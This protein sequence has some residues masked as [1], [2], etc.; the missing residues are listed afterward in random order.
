M[1]RWFGRWVLATVVPALL[2]LLGAGVVGLVTGRAPQTLFRR[3]IHA[4]RVPSDATRAAA[5]GVH[6]LFRSHVDPRVGYVLRSSMKLEMLGAEVNSNELGLRKRAGGSKPAAPDGAGA[7][8]LVVLGD[9]VAFGYGLADGQCL[10]QRIEDLIAAARGETDARTLVAHTVAV[11]G[12]NWRNAFAFLRDHWDELRPT[13]VLFMPIGN[14][15]SDTDGIWETGQRRLIADV[16]SDDPWTCIS[17]AR[18]NERQAALAA[19]VD[20]GELAIGDAQLGPMVLNKDLGGESTRR[21][22]AMADAIVE[23]DAELA[24]RGVRF[25]VLDHVDMAFTQVLLAR[26]RTR[27]PGLA[28][29]PLLADQ[30]P[31]DQLE[32]DPHPNAAA[33]EALARW[34][35]ASLVEELHWIEV[36]GRIAEVEPRYAGRRAA[37]R[38]PT[39]LAELAAQSREKAAKLLRDQIVPAEGEGVNQVYGGLSTTELMGP[40]LLAALPRRSGSIDVELAP[41]AGRADLLPLQVRVEIDGVVAGEIRLPIGAKA[42]VRGRFACGAAGARGTPAIDVKLVADRF[43]VVEEAGRLEMASCRL[44]RLATL[45]D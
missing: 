8:R 7:E 14:D 21:F 3:P 22:D 10:A 38:T 30:R 11:P 31:A 16:G 35:A 40:Q 6:G 26:V 28:T 12:W 25:A 1:A 44:V 36:D 19:R 42:P 27:Q 29:I 18:L 34:T 39:Q 5:A 37:P 43:V 17:V 9:S 45:P 32:D 4:P 2:L 15:L 41:I 23:L 20:R 13:I 33:V 24:V